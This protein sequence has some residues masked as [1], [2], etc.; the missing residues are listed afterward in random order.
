MIWLLTAYGEQPW[1]AFGAMVVVVMIGGIAFRDKSGM[2]LVDP[3]KPDPGYNPFWYSL[4]LFLPVVDLGLSSAWRP[5]PCR[6]VASQYAHAH[7]LLGWILVPIALAG[8]TG[9][10][11]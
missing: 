10:L 6:R 1:R 7:V 9:I 8:I 5:K 4:G 3:A 11:K 2:A